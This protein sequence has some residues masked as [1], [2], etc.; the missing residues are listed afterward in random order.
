MKVN[1][2]VPSPF[3]LTAYIFNV[4]VSSIAMPAPIVIVV[5]FVNAMPLTGSLPSSVYLPLSALFTDR[6]T[7]VVSVLNL[8]P[9]GDAVRTGNFLFAPTFSIRITPFVP[10]VNVALPPLTTTSFFVY[11]SRTVVPSGKMLPT[12][13][14]TEPEAP[15]ATTTL[16]KISPFSYV[17]ENV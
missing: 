15:T 16:S 4:F 1:E 3:S 2:P 13:T 11:A 7:V 17:R 14:L 12:F 10:A 9:A 8:P 5:P 6:V